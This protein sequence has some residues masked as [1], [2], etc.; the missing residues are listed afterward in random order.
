MMQLLDISQSLLKEDGVALSTMMKTE[1]LRYQDEFLGMFF[2]KED[3]LIIKVSPSRV[4]ELIKEGIVREFSFTK[5]VFKEWV[6][7]SLEYRDDY[8]LYLKEALKY[9][10]ELKL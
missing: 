10:K 8:Q 4:Q 5:K 6:L 3:A 9:A 7:I 2:S 1:C